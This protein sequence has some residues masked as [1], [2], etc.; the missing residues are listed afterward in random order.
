MFRTHES[1]IKTIKPLMRCLTLLLC[2]WFVDLKLWREV[3]QPYLKFNSQI[4]SNKMAGYPENSHNF[5]IM[6]IT[7]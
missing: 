2:I 1:G 4:K 5:L 6:F 7:I 3:S